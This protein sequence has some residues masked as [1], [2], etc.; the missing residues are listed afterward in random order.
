MP[1]KGAY[2]IVKPK[3]KRKE[4]LQDSHLIFNQLENPQGF[5]WK[6]K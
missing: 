5:T 6:I 2:P 4:R 1:K 3:G